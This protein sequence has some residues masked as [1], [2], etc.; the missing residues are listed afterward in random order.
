[1]IGLQLEGA[2]VF[3]LLILSTQLV[4]V[5]LVF[6]QLL[7]IIRA[8]ALYLSPDWDVLEGSTQHASA[9]PQKDLL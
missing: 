5:V 9:W 3:E 4:V 7:Q 8:Y 6:G 2:I 1:M